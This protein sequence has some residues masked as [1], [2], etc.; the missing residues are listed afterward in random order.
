MAK[1]LVLQEIQKIIELRKIGHSLNEIKQLTGHSSTSVYKYCREVIVADEYKE[2]LKRKQGGGEKRAQVAWKLAQGEAR[3]EIQNLSHRDK[4]I[5]LAAL[6]WG[7]GTKHELNFCNTDPE[8]IKVFVGCLKELGVVKSDLLVT[9]RIYEDLDQRKVITYW[10]GV[11][12]ISPASIRNVNVL[13]G[14]KVGKLQYGMCRIRVAKSAKYFKLI[15]S[16]IGEIKNIHNK[17][18]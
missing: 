9:V 8:M 18:P 14:K 10:A 16:L 1:F 6:Y 15:M 12:G 17:L 3:K 2:I 4:L 11:L 5:I 13:K 7:E